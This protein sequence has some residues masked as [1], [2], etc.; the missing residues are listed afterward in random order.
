MPTSGHFAILSGRNLNCRDTSAERELI[1]RPASGGAPGTT[2]AKQAIRRLGAKDDV[3]VDV[4][5]HDDEPVR[6][7]SARELRKP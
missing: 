1:K 3:T 6:E 5:V 2:P 4:T 7:V